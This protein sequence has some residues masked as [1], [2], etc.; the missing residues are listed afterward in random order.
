MYTHPENHP[1]T[2]ITEDADHKFVTSTEKDI[3]NNAAAVKLIA[4]TAEVDNER[5]L[6]MVE[7]A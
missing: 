1:A 4:S 7:I 2:M 3:I 5:D 6:Y